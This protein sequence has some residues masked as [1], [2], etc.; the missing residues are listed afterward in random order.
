MHA[1][2]PPLKLDKGGH[3]AADAMCGSLAPS[4]VP[5]FAQYAKD[6][7]PASYCLPAII[8]LGHQP[9]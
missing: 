6:G 2:E 9:L 3:D 7:A 1:G 4:V 8:G 5:P